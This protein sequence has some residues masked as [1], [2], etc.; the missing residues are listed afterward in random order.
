[1]EEEYRKIKGYENYSVSNYG[2]IRN[3]VTGKILKASLNGQGYKR[4]RLNG[5]TIKVHRL[6]SEAFIP[7]ANNKKYIDHIDND[8]TNNNVN[9]LRWVTIQENNF[10]QSISKNN[11]SG[12][13]GIRWHKKKK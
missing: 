7:N 6:V 3:D 5:K 2:N 8:R 13:K 10:N 11:I 1:M 9:N 4:V 12:F